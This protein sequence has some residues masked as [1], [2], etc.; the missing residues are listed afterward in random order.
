MSSPR[1]GLIASLSRN[2]RNEYIGKPIARVFALDL[3]RILPFLMPIR[4]GRDCPEGLAHPSAIAPG[5]G[6]AGLASSPRFPVH[7][8]VVLVN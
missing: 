7:R 6:Q 8:V 3:R 5:K 1:R 4:G 2:L